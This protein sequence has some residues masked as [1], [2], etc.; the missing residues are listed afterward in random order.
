MK[1][2]PSGGNGRRD[3]D[4]EDPSTSERAVEITLTDV[5]VAVLRRQAGV[6]SRMSVAVVRTEIDAAR[7]L[8]VSRRYDDALEHLLSVLGTYPRNRQA[9]D[10]AKTVVHLA[11][12]DG[13]LSPELVAVSLLDSV[14][15]QCSR[16]GQVWPGPPD[17]ESLRALLLNE[18]KGGRCRICAAVWCGNCAART[19]ALQCPDCKEMLEAASEPTGRRRGLKPARRP[20][21]ALIRVFLFKAPPEPRNEEGYVLRTLDA[22]CPEAWGS[23]VRV[24]FI[25]GRPGT[26]ETLARFCIYAQLG[27]TDL[28]PEMTFVESY[29]DG[30]GDHGILASIYERR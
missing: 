28:D 21:L 29:K 26:D 4:G 8:A 6:D 2:S 15:N 24:T 27:T 3:V 19:P 12:G 30:L 18:S 9:L 11:A 20:G 22:L 17:D 7:R 23:H 10:L 14:F 5:G 16:C 13:G 25:V 1:N